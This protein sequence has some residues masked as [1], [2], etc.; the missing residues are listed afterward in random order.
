MKK[1]LGRSDHGADTSVVRG[2]SQESTRGWRV[3]GKE[4]QRQRTQREEPSWLVGE[5]ESAS[6][7]I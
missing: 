5:S 3:L 4:Q 6:E 1:S 2:A 7:L